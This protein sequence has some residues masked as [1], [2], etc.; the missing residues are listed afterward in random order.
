MPNKRRMLKTEELGRGDGEKQPT[1]G[2]YGKER[3]H[4]ERDRFWYSV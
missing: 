4:K 1:E 2:R 3:Y